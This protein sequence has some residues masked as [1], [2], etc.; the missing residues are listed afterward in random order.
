MKNTDF[1]L[2]LSTTTLAVILWFY[3][4]PTWVELPGGIKNFYQAP[5]FWIRVITV[6]LFTVGALLII[7]SRK[8]ER[9]NGDTPAYSRQMALKLSLGILVF[10]LFY[11]FLDVLGIVVCSSLAIVAIALIY[12]ERR[13]MHLVIPAITLP[14]GLYF[15]FLK[16]A[17]IPMPIGILAGFGPF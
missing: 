4:V 13:I 2:G 16:V 15:F 17:S 3:L 5:D 7:F 9:N 11:F 1:Y 6:G 12:G 8:E 14:V 10:F